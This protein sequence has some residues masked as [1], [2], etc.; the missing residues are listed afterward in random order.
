MEVT[1]IFNYG[2]YVV[3]AILAALFASMFGAFMFFAMRG[4]KPEREA[5]NSCIAGH[6]HAKSIRHNRGAAQAGDFPR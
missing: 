5:A 6:Q 2:H 4:A 1:F 3:L